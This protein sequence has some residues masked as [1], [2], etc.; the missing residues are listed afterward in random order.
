MSCLKFKARF[1]ILFV[2]N[3]YTSGQTALVTGGAVRIGRHI[4]LELAKRGYDLVI[5]YNQSESEARETREQIKTLKRKCGLIQA[6]LTDTDILT[7][8]MPDILKVHPGLSLVVNNA[9]VFEK[10]RLSKTDLDLLER[11]LMLHLKVPF[12]LTR[13][14]S[15]GAMEGH[16]INIL[17][18]KVAR[19]VSEY[20]A[21]TLSKKCLAEF[22]KMA[23]RELAP[24]FRVNGIC[25]GAILPPS[26]KDQRYLD[27]LSERLPLK[28]TGGLSSISSAVNFLDENNFITGETLFVDG[29]EHLI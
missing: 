4:A 24:T 27:R 9:S 19:N 11:N 1:C 25:P 13:D 2:M 12:V 29:G 18:A 16:I 22:T 8:F 20:F 3:A 28:T 15:K 21:Y 14:F 6:D 17:D 23:A 10:G 26:G 7:R 5:Q